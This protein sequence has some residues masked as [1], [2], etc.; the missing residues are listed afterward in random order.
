MTITTTTMRTTT[1]YDMMDAKTRGLLKLDETGSNESVAPKEFSK[2]FSK[3]ALDS[4]HAL[5]ASS[6]APSPEIFLREVLSP[7]PLSLSPL[8]LSVHASTADLPTKPEAPMSEALRFKSVA[9]LEK[10]A[11]ET[12]VVGA[13]SAGG[14]APSK[15]LAR[16][17]ADAA[18]RPAVDPYLLASLRRDRAAH[19]ALRSPPHSPATTKLPPIQARSAARRST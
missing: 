11:T 9:Q 18:A 12:E 4:L 15:L 3:V 2:A 6:H 1:L 16:L 5:S 19:K 10:E 7:S 8:S 14:A 17:E 13:I